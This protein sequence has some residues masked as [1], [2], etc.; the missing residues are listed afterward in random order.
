MTRHKHLK[1]LVR[2]RMAKTGESYATARRHVVRDVSPSP[3]PEPSPAAP[4]LP[5]NVPA[6]TCLR[7]LLDAGGVRAPHTREPFTEAMLYGVAGGIGV[8]VFSFL[9]EKEDFASF[10]VAGRH[11]WWDD[12][13]Y[14]RGGC[15][16]LGAEPVV[17]EAGGARAAE[18]Q[19]SGLLESHGPC[20]AWVDMAHLPHR[21]MPEAWS[22]GGY[23]AITVYAVDEAAGTALIGDLTDAPIAVSLKDLAAARGRIKKQKHRLLALASPPRVDDLAAL[24][25]GG[26]AACREGLTGEKRANF[27]LDA[28]RTW[29]ERLR[30]SGGTES[31]ERVYPRGH[32][33]WT[34]L[35]SVTSFVEHYGTG[36]GLGRPLF[37]EFL[38]EAAAATGAAGLR[39]L[40]ERYGALGRE[41]TA[42]AEAALPDEVPALAR[43]KALLAR[44]A[45][46]AAEGAPVE[47]VRAVWDRLEELKR[48]AGE[49]FPLTEAECGELRASLAERVL[50]LHVGEVTA[51]AE[52]GRVMG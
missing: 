12:L 1:Q 3:S 21:A 26:L 15:A 43:A 8:G 4:H 5:G 18:R 24:V 25:R 48:E 19:L 37:A 44:K 7:I 16:R 49:A 31:W 38:E 29:G 41:W 34:G 23:H 6:T 22:G 52:M 42:L 11:L 46:L 9:Y 32:R 35:T 39:E 40:A 33:L 27:R 36:G 14:L 51:H 50:A 30:G 13:A 47:E 28:L 10:Y 20:V 17:R 2:A 45:E